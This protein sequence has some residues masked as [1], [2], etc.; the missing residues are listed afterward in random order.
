MG[1]LLSHTMYTKQ[2]R[3]SNIDVNLDAEIYGCT[4]MTSGL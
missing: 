2:I 4:F 1:A 3:S